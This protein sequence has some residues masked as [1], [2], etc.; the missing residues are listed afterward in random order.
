[1]VFISHS[2]LKIICC[3]IMDN[4]DLKLGMQFM[5]NQLFNSIGGPYNKIGYQI[6]AIENY[7]AKP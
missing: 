1:M 2:A 7:K 6:E 5:D 3:N 4:S